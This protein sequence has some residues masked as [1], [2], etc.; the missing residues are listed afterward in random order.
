MAA[1]FQ[2]AADPR[3]F[4][5]CGGCGLSRT[6]ERNANMITFS[7]LEHLAFLEDFVQA[8]LRENVRD[9]Y[10][11]SNQSLRNRLPAWIKD[12]HNREAILRCVGKLR[13]K[14]AE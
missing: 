8:T 13:Q 9:K 11:W 6:F 5:T 14:V 10:G 3:V 1:R 2:R 12:G 4:L 7:L